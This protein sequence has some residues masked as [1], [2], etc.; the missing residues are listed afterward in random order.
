MK[1]RPSA[2]CRRLLVVGLGT[3]AL[4]CRPTV[5]YLGYDR[6]ETLAPLACP[7]PYRSAYKDVLGKTDADI[8]K[9][10]SIGFNQLFHGSAAD[11]AIYFVSG[12]DQASI[13]DV[14]HNN[15]TRTEGLGLAMVVCAMLDHRDEFDRLWRY[16]KAALKYQSGVLAGYFRSRCDLVQIPPTGTASASRECA[17]PYGLQQFVM[18]LLVARQRWGNLGGSIDY[19]AEAASLF[20]L[21]RGKPRTANDA[22]GGAGGANSV[23][24]GVAGASSGLGGVAG[25]DANGPI[26]PTF[27][28]LTKLPW[29]EPGAN[30][31]Q[32]TGTALIMPGY[33]TLWAQVTGDGFFIDAAFEGRRFLKAVANP[34]TGL[35]PVRAYFNL[36]PFEWWPH[37]SAEAYRALLNLVI[38]RLWATSESW[39]GPQIEELVKFFIG[40]GLAEYGAAYTL[41]GA[42]ALITDHPSELILVNGVVA[43]L[44]NNAAQADFLRAA[45]NQPIP[46][47]PYRY[48]PG[49][50]YLV[51]NLILGGR[52]QVCH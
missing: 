11:E 41:D 35:I 19:T 52:F 2:S 44:S 10:L 36:T 20:E 28:A 16:S 13:R 26:A 48:Y 7:A 5:D 25:S 23:G 15:E 12:T 9:K 22:A 14:L 6:P 24:V 29:D 45:W 34:T 21:M 47:G 17:D 31:S 4:G 32:L 37:F 42:T 39:Q 40:K 27:D 46:T 18:A 30:P 8:D 3:I 33:Y 51:S 38:D 50:L 1:S 43:S 49:L